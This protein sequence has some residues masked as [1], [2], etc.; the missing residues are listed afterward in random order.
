MNP[1][2][3]LQK[4]V[5]LLSI[6]STFCFD[7]SLRK[8]ELIPRVHSIMYGMYKRNGKEELLGYIMQQLH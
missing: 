6:V 7:A 8:P 1:R 5:N 4:K 3:G 2:L